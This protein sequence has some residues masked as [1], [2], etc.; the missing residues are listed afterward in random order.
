M[1]Q[2]AALSSERHGQKRWQ[3]YVSY[4]FAK[5][6]AV[7]PL[8][9]SE[10][11]IAIM[12]LPIAFVRENEAY[13]PVAVLGLEPGKNLY[14]ALNGRWVGQYVPASLRGYPFALVR[15]GEQMVMCVDEESGLVI[16]GPSGELMFDEQGQPTA[17]IRGVLDFLNKV[18]QD[19][20]RTAAICAVLEKSGCIRPWEIT[21]KFDVSN[22]RKIE[23]LYQVD[24]SALNALSDEAFLELRQSGALLLAYGQLLSMQHLQAL[25]Q[26]AD[27]HAKAA[28]PLPIKGD[29]LDLSFLAD[30]DTLSFS[31]M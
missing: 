2:Y 10:L 18:E 1:T 5:G 9:V 3:R 14:V 19:R 7:A 16:D 6:Q 20:L 29:E 11:S 17:A 13:V 30:G 26:L 24:E 27:A 4:A 21:H 8:G 28:A 22:E 12:S 15:S 25:G 31:G 23:G